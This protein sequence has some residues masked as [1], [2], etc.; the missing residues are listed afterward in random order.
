MSVSAPKG[1]SVTGKK[2]WRDLTGEY[3]F[4][5]DELATLE[6]ACREA[7]L[8]ARMEDDLVNEPLTVTG[9][10]GQLVTHPLVQ[11]LRQHRTVMASLFRGLKLPDES[12]NSASN[13]QREAAQSRWA[14]TRGK[15]A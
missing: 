3:E 1:L 15:S 5:A 7:D 6:A 10:T 4:R 2:L 13:Q 12:G 11:E 8:I 14:Q 9:S